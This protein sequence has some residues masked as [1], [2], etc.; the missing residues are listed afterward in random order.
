MLTFRKIL[1]INLASFG[2]N[3]YNILYKDFIDMHNW[4][5]FLYYV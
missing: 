2:K 3:L 4:L 5:G 1:W